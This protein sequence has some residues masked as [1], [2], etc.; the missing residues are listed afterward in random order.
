MN[1]CNFGSRSGIEK[2]ALLLCFH[3][4]AFLHETAVR[5]WPLLLARLVT[6]W[7]SGG[8]TGGEK[9]LSGIPCLH[10]LRLFPSSAGR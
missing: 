6:A 9:V 2:D 1:A 5:N 8:P 3:S 4:L 7:P 10:R